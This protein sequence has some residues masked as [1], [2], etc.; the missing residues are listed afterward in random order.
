MG[1]IKKFLPVWCLLTPLLLSACGDVKDEAASAGRD[2]SSFRAASENYFKGMDDE[3][4]TSSC[5]K[6][7]KHSDGIVL[8]HN[9]IRGRNTWMVWTGGN[10][11]FWD[12]F[13][14]HAFGA[15]DLLKVL[16]SGP[17]SGFCYRRIK[18]SSSEKN[19]RKRG[20]HWYVSDG[21]YYKG[22][23]G[24]HVK[25]KSGKKR[26][27]KDDCPKGS[28]WYSTGRSNRW[29]WYGV[30]NEPC[31]EE[32]K[33]AGKYGL[34]LDRRKKECPPDPFAN[35]A[36]YPGVKIGARGKTVPVGSYYGEPS[37]VVGLRLFPN[38][39]FDEE[40]AKNWD[41]ERYYSDP[42]YYKDKNL[43]RPYRVGMSCGFCHVGPKPTLKSV[44]GSDSEES[45]D[46]KKPGC[47]DPENPEW[48]DLS[49]I[50]GAQ[51]LWIDRVFLWESD[52]SNFLYQVTATFRPGTLDTSFATTDYIGNPRT[53]NAFYQFWPR[54]E[55]A[56]H[57][58]K[59]KLAG[60]EL[61]NTQLREFDQ[62]P[63]T[64]WTP[65]VLK[66]GADSVG[67]LGSLNRVY[68]NIGLFS[69]GW[70]QHVDF[71]LGLTKPISPI[72]IAD[73][74]K[75]SVYW[76]VTEKQTRHM[77]KFLM[78]V[79]GPHYLENKAKQ[80]CPKD[81]NRNAEEESASEA[82]GEYPSSSESVP[83]ESADYGGNNPR[84]CG[85]A[86]GKGEY[87]K[88]DRGKL[89][90][91]DRC[92]RC[93]SSKIPGPVGL[94][95]GCAGP[96]YLECWNTYWSWTK[97]DEFRC[98]MRK[99]VKKNDFLKDNYLSTDLRVPVT[100]LQTNACSPLATNAIADNI[101]D[102]FSSQ[103]YKKL[104]SVGSITV[105]D[106]FT[107]KKRSY[108][109]PAGGRG[110]T[111]VPSLV[112]VWATAPL[113]LNNSLGPFTYGRVS[114]KAREDA[115]DQAMKR[116]LW[117]EN[118]AFD[119]IKGKKLPGVIDRTTAD[120]YFEIP[121]SNV[122][123]WVRWPLRQVCP[124]MVDKQGFVRLGP[125]PKNTPIG[126]LSNI[127]IW[128]DGA[129]LPQSLWHLAKLATAGLPMAVAFCSADKEAAN[130]ADFKK[131][132]RPLMKFA[133]CPDLVVNRGHYFGTDAFA[134]EKG[135][136]DEEKRD[137]IKYIKTF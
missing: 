57:W 34:W 16:S 12:Y 26:Y 42:L 36:K 61:Q 126:L 85:E 115:F 67:A 63:D 69:E 9:E 84:S 81:K 56:K 111:R 19:C 23:C 70:L 54:L 108:V 103:S 29:K 112:S 5:Q 62:I 49:T 97:T 3:R 110:Y 102:N 55:L 28:K 109:M 44:Y 114:V 135:L 66:D 87:P 51:Y 50:V 37:G 11:R 22:F 72:P 25:K 17:H 136:S 53:Q 18:N 1:V 60:G 94:G 77:A 99:E 125:I 47:Y 107:G 128:P 73:A 105:Y 137:L 43:V 101:W 82:D 33:V 14:K 74:K 7:D 31:F 116:L 38:P 88:Q 124:G 130:L 30:V 89:V 48:T 133:K 129:S 68:L 52:W 46:P 117:P 64:V 40:A 78:K 13:A 90:F 95:R 83:N 4:I 134:E 71:L 10:D 123:A 27:S 65:R 76:Q 59:A 106:P 92:A 98:E 100:L 127:E 80:Y 15:F 58:G 24:K 113:L 131:V 6:A 118:R 104:P 121:P 86:Y 32:A 93:H 91:A 132:L 41:A 35:E 96:D 20:G 79:S 119:T 8:T 45:C 120:S 2:A 75:N 39:D 122:P 21:K